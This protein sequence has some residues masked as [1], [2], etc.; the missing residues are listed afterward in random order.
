MKLGVIAHARQLTAIPRRPF[1]A[2]IAR[3]YIHSLDLIDT[4]SKLRFNPGAGG[5]VRVVFRTILTSRIHRQEPV[6]VN[7]EGSVPG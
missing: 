4:V 7:F 1:S 6:E 5:R 3:L 2:L